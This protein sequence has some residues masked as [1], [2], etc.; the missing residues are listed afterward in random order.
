MNTAVKKC[1]SDEDLQEYSRAGSW[2]P[3]YKSKNTTEFNFAN[4]K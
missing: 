1:N 3:K 2:G 4:S